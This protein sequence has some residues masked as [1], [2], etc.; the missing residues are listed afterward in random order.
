MV[1]GPLQKKNLDRDFFCLIDAHQ[2]FLF[3]GRQ[4]KIC[5]R[6][7]KKSPPTKKKC[8]NL[9]QKIN[10]KKGEKKTILFM[11]MLILTT[12]FERF[13]VSHQGSTIVFCPELDFLNYKLSVKERKSVSS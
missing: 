11:A 4:K 6:E 2:K 7:E 9:K 10:P 5:D 8:R 13:I 1:F 3:D 12:S